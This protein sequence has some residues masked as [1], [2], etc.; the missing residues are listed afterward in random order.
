MAASLEYTQKGSDNHKTSEIAAS[1]MARKNNSPAY[2]VDS[3]I[4]GDRD[5]LNEIVGWILNHN[6]GDVNTRRQPAELMVQISP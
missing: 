3:K 4:L 6:D 2:D 5:T 1:S